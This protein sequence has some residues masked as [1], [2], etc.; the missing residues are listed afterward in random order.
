MKKFQK[1]NYYSTKFEAPKKESKDRKLSAN[2]QKFLQ[3]QAKD[4]LE[5]Q[6]LAKQRLDDLMAS[7]DTKSKNKIRKMLKVTKSA[8]KSVLDD[9]VDTDNTAYTLQGPEQP[10]E[11]DYGYVSNEAGALYKKL[12]DKYKACPEEK[13]F[14]GKQ[15]TTT[16]WLFK[17]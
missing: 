9:A 11:D 2:I 6:R 4:E 10:D 12:M 1:S 16:W 5:K 13:I 15:K 14:S 8:N 7:R 3:K 17:C